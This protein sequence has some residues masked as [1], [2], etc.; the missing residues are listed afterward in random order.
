M[1]YFKISQ[2]ALSTDV[3]EVCISQDGIV[4]IKQIWVKKLRREDF[5]A[6]NNNVMTERDFSEALKASF[7]MEIQSEAFCFNRNLSI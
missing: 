7:D 4:F 6:E 1:F 2:G 3:K 5:L